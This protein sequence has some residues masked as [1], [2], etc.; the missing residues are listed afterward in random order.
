M[1][2]PSAR[3]PRARLG[4]YA[5]WMLRDYLINQGPATAIVLLLIAFLMLFPLLQ[6]P[7]GRDPATGRVNEMAANALVRGLLP[8]LGF[9]ATIFATNGIVSN[10]RRFAYYKFLF[11]K[12]VNPVT[13][14]VVTFAVYGIG[15]LVV[16]LGLVG[17]WSVL[18]RPV[19]TLPILV[20]VAL[21]YIAFGG[22]GFLLSA[23]WRFDWLSLV[24]VLFLATEFWGMRNQLAAIRWPARHLLYLLP[25]VHRSGEVY[26]LAWSDGGSAVPWVSIGWLV[27]YGALCLLL[28]M[29]VIRRRPLGT[30]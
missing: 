13:F 14:Y 24:T 23:A 4:A 3:T 8:I 20:V 5:P 6:T 28:G 1:T 10:D 27:G 19:A 17:A 25:P 30:N 2:L 16:T 9:V 22:I 11:A 26:A 12:P 29:V 15:V 21:M 18:I 7:Q